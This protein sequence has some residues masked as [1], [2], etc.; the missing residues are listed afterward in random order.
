MNA[1]TLSLKN[2]LPVRLARATAL[3]ILAGAIILLWIGCGDAKE[4]AST[5]SDE[6]SWRSL[7][8]GSDLSKYRIF[9]FP[10]ANRDRWTAQ[11]GVLSLAA[12]AEG[13]KSKLDLI[14]NKTSDLLEKV[15][16]KAAASR[17]PA[18]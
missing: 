2:A 8:D 12:R 4:S 10:D 7:F 9:A 6:G 18:V 13:S 3:V 11:D 17:K 5:G 16:I 14:I 15:S 1:T